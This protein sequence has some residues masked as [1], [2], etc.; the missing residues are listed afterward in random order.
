[1]TS[2]RNA[3]NAMWLAQQTFALTTDIGVEGRAAA[4]VCNFFSDLH[5]AHS[6]DECY[7]PSILQASHPLT[8]TF[9]RSFCHIRGGDYTNSLLTFWSLRERTGPVTSTQKM[10]RKNSLKAWPILYFVFFKNTFPPY[11]H[12]E[13]SPSSS[14][15]VGRGGTAAGGGAPDAQLRHRVCGFFPKQQIHRQR[16]KPVWHDRQ[17]MGVEGTPQLCS[18][19]GASCGMQLRLYIYSSNL[20]Q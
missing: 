8:V 18:L 20:L 2:C 15:G 7:I 5:A 10:A 1:M 4:A 16:G 17:R 9:E 3:L 12:P 13:R 19:A 6:P 11:L 14:E